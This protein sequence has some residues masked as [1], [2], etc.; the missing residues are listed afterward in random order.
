MLKKIALEII[1]K[2]LKKTATKA[3]T[4]A[5]TD[6]AK[7]ASTVK[8]RAHY[9]NGNPVKAYTRSKTA[10]DLAND[11]K[12][13]PNLIKDLSIDVIKGKAP[14]AIYIGRGSKLGNP[15]K[16]GIDGDRAD[17]IEKFRQALWKDFGIKGEL[18]DEIIKLA[19]LAQ[20]GKDLKLSCFCAPLACH[21]DVI[22]KAIAYVIKNGDLDKAVKKS[23]ETVTKDVVKK[24]VK[25]ATEDVRVIVAGSRGFNDFDKLTSE[26]NK[27]L[28]DKV[29]QK[30]FEIVSGGARGA[31]KLG[32]KYARANDATIK[33]FIPDWNGLG[34]RAGMVRNEEMAKYATH[35]VA[36][37][38]GVS[39]GTKHMINFAKKSGLKVRVVRTD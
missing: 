29:K 20:S 14:G 22:K 18:Y 24:S 9:R 11:L 7:A 15:F 23:V 34:K 28:G 16:I 32:E 2:V 30:G 4:E 36:F 25:A 13:T 8:V 31:D 21:G 10:A 27:Y 38:D 3:A 37:W 19:K 39:L 6:I 35:L 5:A 17:V 12:P 1:K 26:L 33:Q